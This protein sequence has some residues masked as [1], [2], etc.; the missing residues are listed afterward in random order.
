M[1][2]HT[3]KKPRGMTQDEL[4]RTLSYDP[5]TGI[6]R[7][8]VEKKGYSIGDI[9]GKPIAS[10]E[11]YIQIVI[12]GHVYAAHRLAWLYVYGEWPTLYVDHINRVRDDNR[13]EN[14]RLATHSQSSQNRSLHRNNTSGVKGVSFNK[15]SQKW[16]A[17]INV[18]RRFKNLGL[19]EKF[20]DAVV[21]RKNAEIEFHPFRVKE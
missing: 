15:V 12:G 11:K 2:A 9:A 14:L 19:F 17:Y 10:N 6:F 4:K 21:A 3:W 1:A 8:R 13:I 20:E 16:S 18:N 7:W 5:S